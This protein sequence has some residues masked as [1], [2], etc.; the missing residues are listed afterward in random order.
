MK[1]VVI[2]TESSGNFIGGA[3]L[4]LPGLIDG[5]SDRRHDVH[6]I[7]RGMPNEKVR[8]QIAKT[9]VTLHSDLWKIEAIV[10]DTSPVLAKWLNNLK[11]EVM[12]VSTS[13]DMG[14]VVL[15]MLDPNIATLAIGHNDS[16]TYYEP[17]RHYGEFLTRAIGVS[18]E[19]CEKYALVSEIA[20]ERIDWIPYGVRTSDAPPTDFGGT[21]LKMVY[22]GRVEEE[23]KRVSDIVAAVK[24][25]SARG[26][27]F[28]LQ[29]V[30]DGE[31][32]PMVRHELADEIAAGRVVLHG[33]L[34]GER[35]ID[36]VRDSEVFVL[37]SAYEGFC[38]ALVEAMANG[39]APVV[40]DIRSG[41]KQLVTD[42][43]NGF[44]VPIGDIEAFADKIEDLAA[45]REKLLEFRRR[46]WE[47]G[48]QYSVER[49]VEAY[50]HCFEMA[51]TDARANPRTPDPNF[52]LMESCRSNYP[53]WMRRIK[54][55]LES[56]TG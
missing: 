1:I 24:R 6:L 42:G 29:V 31:S 18:D 4:F 55:K 2:D 15:P 39:C 38:I 36:I 8:P 37:A 13:A 27:D 41:N 48:R 10:D 40:T 33:W 20:Q 26:V 21:T 51:I 34:D 43:I 45:D 28:R 46:A 5:L 11:P 12:L 56:L 19:I 7:T 35:V 25:I 52:P 16:P 32:M 47:T 49:M 9:G 3:Q 44:M 30:G 53:L 22:V 14:W 17:A 23:Q 54:A 50:E